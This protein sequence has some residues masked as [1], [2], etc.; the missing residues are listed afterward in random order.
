[1][2]ELIPKVK[3]SISGGVMTVTMIDE[4]NRNTLGGQLLAELM[5]AIDQAEAD[6]AVRVVVVTNSGTVFCAGANLNEQTSGE[7]ASFPKVGLGDLFARIR[8]SPLPFVGRIAGHAVAGGLGLA[9]LMD[10]SVVIDT[11]KHGFTEVRI[12]VAPAV[13]SVICL[14]KMS[15]INA[16]EAML[17][18]N[19][20]L[21]PEAVRLGLFNKAVPTEDL[22][23]EVDAIVQDLIAGG[24]NALAATKTLFETVPG[25]GIEDALAWTGDLSS[26]LFQSDEGQEGMTAY[27]TKRKANWIPESTEA[28]S[29]QE[30]GAAES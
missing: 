23:A 26:S 5:A 11:A 1:M 22:D 13:I 15:R 29:P 14:Q 6:P 30:T 20:F 10:I 19:R 28:Q 4:E 16:T 24:P 18:G 7:T 9:A 12:G 3:T 17:R 21:A 27:L 25:M 8:R 2:T